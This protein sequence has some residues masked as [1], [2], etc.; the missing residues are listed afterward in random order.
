MKGIW[1]VHSFN[2]DYLSIPKCTGSCGY[3]F[4]KIPSS[5]KL[6][7]FYAL[8]DEINTNFPRSANSSR[9][10][11]PLPSVSNLLNVFLKTIWYHII[12]HFFSKIHFILKNKGSSLILR[13]LCKSEY[14]GVSLWGDWGKMKYWKKGEKRRKRGNKWE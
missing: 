14:F 11:S 9:S 8:L 7:L 5:I 12:I 4:H 13:S 2:E 10:I 3:L 1:N 6:C